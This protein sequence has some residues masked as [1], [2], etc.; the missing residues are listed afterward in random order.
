MLTAIIDWSLNN[1]L[2]VL[3]A[4]ALV[5]AGGLWAVRDLPIDAFPDT[6]PV[7]IQINTAAP[8][9]APEAVERQITFRIEQS[10]GGLKNIKEVRSIS[11]F[12]LSQIVVTFED[13][14]DIYFAR[15]VVSERLATIDWE[16]YAPR[17][18]LGPVTT[19]LGEVF[20]YA[21]VGEGRRA[22]SRARLPRRDA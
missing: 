14:T 4:F 5:F 7:Q 8:S 21:V 18:K 19:G 17:P 11:R 22:P 12:G 10:L 16:P 9:L 1:R 6:T 2:V 15:Q 20:H 13:G 3:F